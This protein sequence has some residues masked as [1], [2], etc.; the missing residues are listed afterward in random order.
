MSDKDTKEIKEKGT[1]PPAT[2]SAAPAPEEPKKA[3]QPVTTFA[4]PKVEVVSTHP[5][6][7]TPT[8][9]IRRNQT[10]VEKLNAILAQIDEILPDKTTL[11]RF[12]YRSDN[13]V[14]ILRRIY[15]FVSVTNDAKVFDALL[16]FFKRD[17]NG[18]ANQ[19]VLLAGCQ[20]LRDTNLRSRLS[21]FFTTFNQLATA[22]KF[23]H[24]MTL[25]IN[26]IS[27]FLTNQALI[28]WITVKKSNI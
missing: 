8:V 11:E 12:G 15:E 1:Q 25:N 22:S 20:G 16:E 24:P 28:R 18:K 9:P 17:L 23:H 10:N 27:R 6:K 21:V 3:L 5:T 4:T 7:Q 26:C 14:A 2:T 13:G 19:Q